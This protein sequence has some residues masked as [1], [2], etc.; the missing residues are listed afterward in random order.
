[1]AVLLQAAERKESNDAELH[2]EVCVENL[3]WFLVDGGPSSR[4]NGIL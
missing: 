3:V 2:V 4:Q 1:M